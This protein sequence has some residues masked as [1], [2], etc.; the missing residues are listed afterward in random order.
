MFSKH[1]KQYQIFVVFFNHYRFHCFI[2]KNDNGLI[3]LKRVA[4]KF[5][6]LTPEY[7]GFR[8]QSTCENNQW[9]WLNLSKSVIHQ[10]KE[11]NSKVL[12]SIRFADPAPHH[13]EDLFAR[14]YLYLQSLYMM[15]VYDYKFSREILEIIYSHILQ[16]NYGDYSDDMKYIVQNEFDDALLFKNV[17]SKYKLLK[18]NIPVQSEL[19][20]LVLFSK[21]PL[22]NLQVYESTFDGVPQLLGLNHRGVSVLTDR[23][24]IKYTIPWVLLVEVRVIKDI[25][26]LTLKNINFS[27]LRIVQYLSPSIEQL[28]KEINVDNKKQKSK[29]IEL[30]FKFK[31]QPIASDFVTDCIQIYSFYNG[32]VDTK[33]NL[34]K[35]MTKSSKN[36]GFKSLIDIRNKRIN[37]AANI[38][39][40]RLSIKSIKMLKDPPIP[41][42]FT[43]KH[44]EDFD[45]VFSVIP[46]NRDN[47]NNKG[48][49]MICLP[50]KLEG[51]SNLNNIFVNDQTEKENALFPYDQSNINATNLTMERS[52]EEFLSE[53]QFNEKLL[54][55]SEINFEDEALTF[56]EEI[57]E[58]IKEAE[59]FFSDPNLKNPKIVDPTNNSEK[60][61]LPTEMYKFLRSQEALY[62]AI[63]TKINGGSIQPHSS[64]FNKIYDATHEHFP[65]G[66]TY[67][68]RKTSST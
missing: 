48:N 58:V 8:Y 47:R 60:E 34:N 13:I 10:V 19:F 29:Y 20:T 25:C 52:F 53:T 61:K 46:F 4:E 3:L 2:V 15:M 16:I 63:S 26:I 65:N 7:Y 56:T 37:P 49:T 40:A 55:N 59:T 41:K 18:G 42:C 31:T 1:Q 11:N 23:L 36:K 62:N 28:F 43:L 68:H 50:A 21:H 30:F 39:H 35:S 27:S 54:C 67:L 6:I 33:R 24:D 64:G 66:I 22:Y 32:Y 57:D 14:H 9:K 44:V 51:I 17:L 45:L 12:F 5:D 38:L